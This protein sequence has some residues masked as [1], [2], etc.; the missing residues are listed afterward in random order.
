MWWPDGW[1]GALG[2]EDTPEQYVQHLVDVFREV[3]RVLRDDGVVWL[4]LG[5]CYNNRTKVRTSSHQPALNSYEDDVW[6]ER[7]K[8]GG[9]RMLNIPGLKE[10]DLIMIPARAAIALQSD[11]WYVR[12]EV[13]WI[14]RNGM[15]SP[16]TDRPG[17]STEKIFLLSKSKVYFYDAEAIRIA[18]KYGAHHARY[19]GTYTRHK[20]EQVQHNDAVAGTQHQEG[21]RRN[22]VNPMQRNRRDT[23]W[24]FDSLRGIL[25]GSQDM[26]VNPDGEPLALPV[27]PKGLKAAHF[28]VFPPKLIEP[29]IKAGSSERGNCSWCGKPWIRVDDDHQPQCGCDTNRFPVKPSLVLDPFMGAG[30]TGMVAKQLGRDYVGIELSPEYIDMATERIANSS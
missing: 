9:V 17:T 19:Q 23:D 26:L 24:W 6:A 22:S 2:A 13:P 4:N 3:R 20:I 12:A 15:P 8:R 27:N 25:D 29:L 1:V 28:A 11:G 14:K 16:V 18:S 5:D 21:L 7:A 10:K 30:T